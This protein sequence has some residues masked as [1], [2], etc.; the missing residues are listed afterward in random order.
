M[1]VMPSLASKGYLCQWYV[2]L[3]RHACNACV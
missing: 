3:L 2:T 1:A